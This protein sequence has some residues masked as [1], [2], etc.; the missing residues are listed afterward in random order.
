MILKDVRNSVLNI[1]G[2][3]FYDSSKHN[4]YYL[5]EF[6][7]SK[8]VYQ[9]NIEDLRTKNFVLGFKEKM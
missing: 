6:L 4:V 1:N 2:I 3:S 5:C 8:Y 9:S 7:T